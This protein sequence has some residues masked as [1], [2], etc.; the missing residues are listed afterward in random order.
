MRRVEHLAEGVTLYL[1]DCLEVLPT[2][3]RTAAIVSDVPYGMDWDTDS[4][5]FS[6]GNSER[7]GRAQQQARGKPAGRDNWGAIKGDNVPFDPSPWLDFRECIIWGSNHYGNRLPSGTTLVWMKKP[8][9][10]F[11]TFL[12]D[13]EIGFQKGGHGVYIHFEQFP[14]PS[15]MTEHDGRSPAHPT[16]KP[17]GLMAWCVGR[18]KAG[19]IVDPYMGSGT[20]GIAAVKRG[21]RFVGVEI[22]ATH[23]D[24]ACRRISAALKEPDMFIAPPKPIKQESF[25]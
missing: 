22:D 7:S 5:R 6:G 8:P 2:L 21:R 16:Q 20:T 1:G 12:S 18:V 14:P 25:V 9:Q 13:A 15:R 23:F 19:T 24:T 17:I 3:D 10:L 11:G 4:T